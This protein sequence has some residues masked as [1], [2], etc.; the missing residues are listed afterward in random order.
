MKNN[1]EVFYSY[2]FTLRA[3]IPLL[4]MQEKFKKIIALFIEAKS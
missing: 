1:L 2:I 4:F 3:R